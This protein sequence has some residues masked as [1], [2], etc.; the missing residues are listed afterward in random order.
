ME[1]GLTDSEELEDRPSLVLLS[2]KYKHHQAACP[3]HHH[4]CG[5]AGNKKAAGDEFHGR[6]AEKTG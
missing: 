3:I 1:P 4:E 2:L 6:F 5:I